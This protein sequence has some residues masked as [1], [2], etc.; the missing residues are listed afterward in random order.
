MSHE[1]R[2][3]P[4][5][6]PP[7]ART[8]GIMTGLCLLGSSQQLPETAQCCLCFVAP[9]AP[10][11]TQD[12]FSLLAMSSYS[13]SPPCVYMGLP[14]CLTCSPSHGLTGVSHLLGSRGSQC[15]QCIKEGSKVRQPGQVAS[16]K[17]WR[18]GWSPAVGWD[19]CV[20]LRD[21]DVF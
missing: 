7:T 18:Q 15:P 16:V 2:P 8:V 4:D 1:K 13:S 19:G 5:P 10:H 3:F 12:S 14:G 17:G 6:E 11:N 21:T 20:W 9:M